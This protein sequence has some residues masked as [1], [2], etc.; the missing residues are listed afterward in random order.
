LITPHGRTARCVIWRIYHAG[1]QRGIQH[2]AKIGADV[3]SGYTR[4]KTTFAFHAGIYRRF[5]L[6]DLNLTPNFI[7]FCAIAPRVR[8]SFF[9]T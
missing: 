2:P 4:R 8:P 3:K 5:R 1:S 6:T 9:A 7:A